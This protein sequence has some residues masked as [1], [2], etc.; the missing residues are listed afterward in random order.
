MKTLAEINE[1]L[2]SAGVDPAD[3]TQIIADIKSAVRTS[4]AGVIADKDNELAV[5]NNE[6][7][8]LNGQITALEKALAAAKAASD[9]A[10]AEAAGALEQTRKVVAEHHAALAAWNQAAAEADGALVAAQEQTQKVTAE[11]T[12]TIEQLRQQHHQQLARAIEERDAVSTQNRQFTE[13]FLSLYGEKRASLDAEY[14]RSVADDERAATERS[15]VRAS[16]DGRYDLL[17]K[18]GA[19]I[20]AA[21]AKPFLDRVA[22]ER[23]AQAQAA[24]AGLSPEQLAA[25]NLAPPTSASA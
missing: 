15:K 16:L 18:A 4:D 5:L 21:L 23:L 11:L 19:E 14:A 1:V 2:K 25:L 10:S 3:L 6:I 8:V 9:Q 13:Q 20:A 7:A 22:T 12:A 17:L 24:L